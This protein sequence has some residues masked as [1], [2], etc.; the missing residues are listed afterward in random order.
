MVGGQHY[1]DY[2]S[3]EQTMISTAAVPT[4]PLMTATE[5]AQKHGSDYVELVDGQVRELPM[6][7]PKHA[8]SCVRIARM[9]DEC[10][11]KHDLGHVMSNDSY[12]LVKQNPDTV[13][14]ADVSFY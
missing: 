5:F 10:A 11:E 12:V 13:R 3:E 6:P 8:K 14:G 1:I 2:F 7:F 9:V 4:A